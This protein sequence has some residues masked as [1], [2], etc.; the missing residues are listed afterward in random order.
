MGNSLSFNDILEAAE[1][2]SLDEQEV[3]LEIIYK[4]MFDKKR[5]AIAKDIEDAKEEFDKGLS[6]PISADD[7][8]KEITS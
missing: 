5:S 4:R 8:I 6:K 7:L 1:R 2:L 3:L